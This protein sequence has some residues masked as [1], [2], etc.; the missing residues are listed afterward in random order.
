LS[1]AV[2]GDMRTIAEVELG[3]D[4]YQGWDEGVLLA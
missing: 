4:H 3:R 2:P 1:T